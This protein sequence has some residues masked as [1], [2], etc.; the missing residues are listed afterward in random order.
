MNQSTRKLHSYQ[1]KEQKLL[2]QEACSLCSCPAQSLLKTIPIV[3]RSCCTRS[4]W[5]KNLIHHYVSCSLCSIL[6]RS[7]DHLSLLFSIFVREWSRNERLWEAAR[8]GQH[9]CRKQPLKVLLPKRASS[10][11]KQAD[12]SASQDSYWKA[13]PNLTTW[14][15]RNL[16]LISNLNNS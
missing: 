8:A 12:F 10:T 1:E 3:P 7:S 2:P 13:V 16:H 9:K 5:L 15:V 6:W 14:V 4:A 11:R